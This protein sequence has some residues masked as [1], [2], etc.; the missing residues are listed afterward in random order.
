VPRI[1][2]PVLP[3]LATLLLSPSVSRA[4]DEPGVLEM[5][6]KWDVLPQPT[7]KGGERRTLKAAA[8]RLTTRNI[9]VAGVVIDSA[10]LER[11]AASRSGESLTRVAREEMRRPV[12]V[13]DLCYFLDD[14]L[15]QGLDS[16][17]VV[18]TPDRARRVGVFLHPD[19]VFKGRARRYG[20]KYTLVP[21]DPPADPIEYAPPTDGD[22]L[23]P[24][25][26]ARYSNP[27]EEAEMLGA[28]TAKR[29]RAKLGERMSSLV[30]QLRA[31]GAE[32]AV[33]STVRHRERGYLMWGAF[34]LARSSSA[35]QLNTR[36]A[37]VE[38]YNRSWQL[39]VP[40]RW[41]HPAGWQSTREEARK[42]AEAYNVVYA[43]KNGAKRSNHYDGK[44]IDLVAVGLPRAL[45][46]KAP[47]GAEKTFDLSGANESRD[48]NLTPHLVRWVEAH[49]GLRK[50][51][52]DYPH[53]DDA[54]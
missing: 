8:A 26:Y 45:T 21:I 24:A 23:G 33:E 10:L 39:N 1:T 29:P 13:R 34:W 7:R 50:L 48:L 53:W 22:P 44:A 2:A 32:V 11:I 4:A 52:G 16:R 36:L 47:D 9:D 19:D 37:K 40:I 31:Q 28:L 18:L 25:W 12:D 35:R 27:E 30:E 17:P 54:K 20:K 46:L 15:A 42:M 38:G 3:L 51:E 43:T 49:F 14:V 6:R 41:R 5:N